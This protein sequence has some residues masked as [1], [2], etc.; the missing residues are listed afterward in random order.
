MFHICG[1][2][3]LLASCHS[4]EHNYLAVRYLRQDR[5]ARSVVNYQISFVAIEVSVAH[6]LAFFVM[7]I[8]NIFLQLC[9]Y[10]FNA[11]QD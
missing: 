8:G 7:L 1:Q 5:A 11:L 9:N 6:S 10:A 2:F 4:L 3:D